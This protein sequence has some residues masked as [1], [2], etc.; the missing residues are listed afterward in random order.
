[1]R[2]PDWWEKA[3]EGIDDAVTA[4]QTR[5]REKINKKSPATLIA[6]KNP[7]LF[8]A[9]VSGD[10]YQYAGM[11][12]DAFL[13]SSEETMF[14]NVLESTAISICA[15]AKGGRKS[16]TGNIDLE[17]EQNGERTIIQIKSGPNWGNS[18]QRAKL[19]K[20]FMSAARV[21]RQGNRKTNVK[22]VEGICYGARLTRDMGAYWKLVGHDFWVDISGWEGTANAVMDIIGVHTRNGLLQARERGRE[23]IVKYM[24]DT[25]AATQDNEINWKKLLDLVMDP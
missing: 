1:M 18:G 7:F 19:E 15:Q 13:S 23:K 21:L 5:V 14:G 20:D 3:E 22:C 8:R 4:F 9:R 12:I 11:I 10:A 25:G 17:Y 2:Y 16:S 6:S 24:K